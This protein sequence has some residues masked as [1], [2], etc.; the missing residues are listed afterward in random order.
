MEHNI[1]NLGCGVGKGLE[2]QDLCRVASSQPPLNSLP[3]NLTP[4]SGLS[5]HYTHSYLH[6]QPCTYIIKIKDISF[7][8][9]KY[10]GELLGKCLLF[11]LA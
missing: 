3:G 4:S 8:E 7:K 6:T 2:S 1:K 10:S 9:K 11:F 5:G